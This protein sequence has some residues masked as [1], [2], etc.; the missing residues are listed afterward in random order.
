MEET[1]ELTY[2]SSPEHKEGDVTFLPKVVWVISFGRV[3]WMLE[4]A[5]ARPMLTAKGR[6]AAMGCAYNIARWW[7]IEHVHREAKDVDISF[8]GE[9]AMP[10]GM[11]PS[12]LWLSM[13]EYGGVWDRGRYPGDFG[14][15]ESLGFLGD[16]KG[17]AVFDALQTHGVGTS[18]G[19]VWRPSWYRNNFME[20]A[21]DVMNLP[22]LPDLFKHNALQDKGFCDIAECPYPYVTL[23]ARPVPESPWRALR[24]KREDRTP[25]QFSERFLAPKWGVHLREASICVKVERMVEEICEETEEE[26]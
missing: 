16:M 19:L 2:L 15:F 18:L 9:V 22:R 11:V 26:D 7:L 4:K 5:G 24:L 12:A 6:E 23:T 20:W 25:M 8:P 13:R 1:V 10:Q 3:V 21:R 14:R 17:M